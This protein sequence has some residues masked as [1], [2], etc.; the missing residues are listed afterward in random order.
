MFEF[1][2]N[3]KAGKA[4]KNILSGCF[5]F[6][7]IA[8]AAYGLIVPQT[9]HALDFSNPIAWFGD[10]TAGAIGSVF[11]SIYVGFSIPIA[12][13]LLW[14]SAELLEMTIKYSVLQ[15]GQYIGPGSAVAETWKVL[16]D[17]G[18]MFFIFILLYTAIMT[19]LGMGSGDVKKI[20][21]KVIIMAVLI[22]FSFF[23][24]K[25]AID[26]SNIVSIA[27][28]KQIVSST[29]NGDPSANQPEFVNI[30]GAFMCHLGL[31]KMF[32]SDTVANLGQYFSN[33][34]DGTAALLRF[35]T[36]GSALMVMLAIIMFAGC[37]LFLYR[38][39]SIL[40]LLAFSPL[41]FAAMAFPSDKYSGRWTKPLMEVCISA[42][43]FMLFTWVTLRLAGSL[44][45][46]QNGSIIDVIS[47][48]AFTDSA[49]NPGLLT[50]NIQ[51]S[52]NFFVIAAMMVATLI[53]SK[54]VG[55]AGAGWGLKTM[56]NFGG[57]A[58]GK[59]GNATFGTLGYAGRRTLGLAGRV[60]A[61]SEGL[62]KMQTGNSLF[63]RAI[64]KSVRGA[65]KGTAE[66]SFDARSLVSGFGK[67]GGKGGYDGYLKNTIED[68][69]KEAKDL[70]PSDRQTLNAELKLKAAQEN[71]TAV[72]KAGRESVERVEAEFGEK[73]A[74]EEFEAEREKNKKRAEELGTLIATE[75][76]KLSDINGNLSS[77]AR[78]E[79]EKKVGDMK[80]EL[81][82]AK[83]E[84]NK[85]E[86]NLTSAMIKTDQIKKQIERENAAAQERLVAAQKEMDRI[87]GVSEDDA[88]KRFNESAEKAKEE[89]E[90]KERYDAYIKSEGEKAEK[91]GRDKGLTGEDLEKFLDKREKIATKEADRRNREFLDSLKDQEKKFI[92]ENKLDSL[93]KK[94]AMEYASNLERKSWIIGFGNY[95]EKKRGEG[96]PSMLAGSRYAEA[97]KVRK[98]FNKGKDD[99]TLKKL[100]AEI[101]KQ[102]EGDKK[103]EEGKE[104]KKGDDKK[105]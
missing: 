3:K 81:S 77:V 23:F 31:T 85:A 71:S 76:G 88:K 80:I 41:A 11:V 63:G 69:V 58:Q 39:V 94:R 72:S 36:L 12:A 74:R 1:F 35:A 91:E 79:I 102:S 28:Y 40:L 6:V 92:E 55:A 99:E 95:L 2:K 20:V 103:K 18:N 47:S 25:V 30:G 15:L 46:G 98:E 44:T 78:A 13:F 89:K 29:C 16:R 5:V 37:I 22:N 45:N 51:A 67:A 64:A 33:G 93:G 4:I 53:I 42:P 86:P 65:A 38:F 82:F 9:A 101:N 96:N 57:W 34:L 83:A 26:A 61:D 87:K 75:E 100:V 84:A 54:E 70:G 62:K 32:S 27:F 49:A 73:K 21:V 104:E 105:E 17:F 50:Q 7:F 14:G 56:K 48:K 59:L 43:V 24:T 19:I 97:A 60:V 66:A 68:R 52:L 8:I 90:A 10:K